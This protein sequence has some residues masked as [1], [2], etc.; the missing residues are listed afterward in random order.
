MIDSFVVVSTELKKT[1]KISSIEL[2]NVKENTKNGLW[3]VF[4]QR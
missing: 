2:L 4:L 1:F 3:V